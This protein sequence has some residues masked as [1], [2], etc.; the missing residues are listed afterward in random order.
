LGAAYGFCLLREAVVAVVAVDGAF[1]SGCAAFCFGAAIADLVVLVGGG[2]D[3]CVV[4]IRDCFL[5]QSVDAVVLIS[6]G[7]GWIADNIGIDVA[8][9]VKL[10]NLGALTIG[11]DGITTARYDAAI[12]L[13]V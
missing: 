13:L 6:A 9:A 3:A 5:R 12:G 1:R 2:S 4:A 8:E 11:A 10:V 7:D